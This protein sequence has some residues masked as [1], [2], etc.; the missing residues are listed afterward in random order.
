MS[1][2]EIICLNNQQK[3]E[4]PLGTT[5]LEIS[6]DL[7]VGMKHQV[8]GAFVNNKLKE[9][10]YNIYKP[11]M[12]E[13]IDISH[14]DGQRMYIRSLSFV[15]Q[16]AV[17][18]L[19][20]GRRLNIQHAISRGLY[21]E[22]MG[23]CEPLSNEAIFAIG[24]KMRELIAADLPIERDEV[25]SDEAIALFEKEGYYEKSRLFK[26]RPQLYSSVYRLGGSIDY[27]Y[28]YLLPSTG[29]LEVFDLVKYYDGMLLIPPKE[30]NPSEIQEIVLRER[31][32][33]ILQEY[34]RWGN[35]LDVAYLGNLNELVTER[36]IS[37]FIKISEVLQEK[38][39]GYIADQICKREKLPRVVLIAG[40]SSSGKTTCAQRL[41]IQLKVAGLRPV[42]LSLDN[43]FVDR[44]LT[45]LDADGEYDF[46]SIHAIDIA[47]LN[48][49]LQDLLDGKEIAVPKF[50]F[51][52]GKRFFD[53]EKLQIDEKTIIIAEGI[54]ALT[55]ELTQ[56]IE[57]ADKFHIYVSALTTLSLDNHN[58]IPTSD[59]RLIRRMIRD[60]K[61]RGYSALDT[62]NRWQS[63]RRG[64]EKN[65][66]PFQENADVMFN[67]AVHYELGVL[68]RYA[69]PILQEVPKNDKAYREAN[70]L[71]KFLSY[72]V[73]IP[74]EEIP[75][76][77][78][79]REFLGGS[80]F[81]YH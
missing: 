74:D 31:L 41:A 50:S 70:R 10:S 62:I 57:D 39:M 60:Y 5:L 8:L 9:L 11:K 77:S 78:I 81:R 65:I 51:I 6:A 73:P 68:K 76:T 40:P 14:P 43:Y 72:I 64:E 59:V 80:S 54:H 69:D 24:D 45:P 15:L 26:S 34:T 33:D 52:E 79:L 29:Y 18:L 61:Y 71:L 37:E 23:E 47:Y 42:T 67:T 44:E 49:D 48:K 38:K 12:V 58:R 35:I 27:Y 4:Y 55:P 53:G 36:K 16:K 28:G 75:P 63:V 66:F 7:G 32:F 20:P 13:F 56:E 22:V 2:I 19:Y 3:K 1:M 30:D 21:C 25:V 46:E 17:S